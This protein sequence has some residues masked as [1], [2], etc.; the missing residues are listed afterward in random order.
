MKVCIVCYGFRENNIRLQ[1]W[2]Y[3]SEIASGLINNDIDV[4]VITDG[5]PDNEFTGYVKAMVGGRD[6]FLSQFNR[7]V[8]AYRHP[9]SSFKPIVYA[10]A[11]ESESVTLAD[12]IYDEPIEIQDHEEMWEPKNYNGKFSGSVTVRNALVYS[13]N[14]PSIKI[15]LKTGMEN[16]V[17]YAKKLGITSPIMPVPSIALG[18]F[19]VT[20]KGM[21]CAPPL[22][23]RYGGS[24]CSNPDPLW[25]G[26]HNGRP[27]RYMR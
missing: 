14:I 8:K 2:R 25:T 18:A 11:L 10:A 22:R 21:L 1:P 9:G 3:I 26:R 13:K 27:E 4:S 24:R 17:Y 16:V 5:Q 7:A 6:Y 15:L 19:E 20:D 23:L 12:M